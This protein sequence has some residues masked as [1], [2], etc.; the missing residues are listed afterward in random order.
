MH[1]LYLKR[2]EELS[3]NQKQGLVIYEKKQKVTEDFSKLNLN[4]KTNKSK[5][6]IKNLEA[7]KKRRGKRKGISNNAGRFK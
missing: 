6:D 5:Y 3:K 2:K 1:D 7:F 4:L